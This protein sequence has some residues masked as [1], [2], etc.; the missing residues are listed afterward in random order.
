MLKHFADYLVFDL[1]ALRKDTRQGEALDFFIYDTIKSIDPKAQIAGP[2]TCGWWFYWNSSAG[3]GDK[4]K[5]GDM[6][7]LP[8]WIGAI[9]D[10]DKKSG[11]RT[12]DIFDIHAYGEYNG[13]GTPDVVAAN[14]LRS[15][16]AYW[17]PTY[18]VVTR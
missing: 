17:D 7:L 4:A 6:D 5:H 12:L 2:T 14:Q 13:E 10:A 11:Q 1:L 18:T 15:P 3:W 8:W 9:A 16:R